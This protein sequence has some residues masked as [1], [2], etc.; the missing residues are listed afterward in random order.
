MNRKQQ[1]ALARNNRE[2]VLG[3]IIPHASRLQP[4]KACRQVA[5]QGRNLGGPRSREDSTAQWVLVQKC[6]RD[7]FA[8]R[9]SLDLLVFLLVFLYVCS[10]FPSVVVSE[11]VEIVS[12][13]LPGEASR[14][15]A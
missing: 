11:W 5:A 1:K 6:A 13:S 15:S 4:E 14:S 10:L 8:P 3:L 12:S 7:T 9:D 2:E